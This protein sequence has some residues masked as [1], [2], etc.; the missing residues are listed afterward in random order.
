MASST[1]LF[2]VAYHFKIFREGPLQCRL[3]FRFEDCMKSFP[4]EMNENKNIKY[5][6][7]VYV[8]SNKS[9]IVSTMEAYN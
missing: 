3:Y 5:L 2:A 1:Q 4:K 6:S 8:S 7:N 9:K